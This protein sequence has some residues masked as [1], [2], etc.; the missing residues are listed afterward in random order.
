MRRAESSTTAASLLR[1]GWILVV[2]LATLLAWMATAEGYRPAEEGSGD[3]RRQLAVVSLGERTPTTWVVEIAD[4]LDEGRFEIVHG[5]QLRGRLR[6]RQVTQLEPGVDERIDQLAGA[7]KR[8]IAKFHGTGNETAIEAL[9]TPFEQA[10]RQPQAFARRPAFAERLFR[11]GMILVRAYRNLGETEGARGIARDLYRYLPGLEPSLAQ[12]RLEDIHFYY[13]ER[14]AVAATGA[15]LT[16]PV[17]GDASCRPYLN[18]TPISGGDAKVDSDHTHVVSTRCGDEWGPIWR[19]DLRPG[20]YATVPVSQRAPRRVELANWSRR[21]RRRVSQYLRVITHWTD[22]SATIGIGRPPSDDGAG[23]VA[24][25]VPADGE[26][27]WSTVDE[28][29]DVTPALRR[30]LPGVALQSPSERSAGGSD[31]KRWLDWTL[32]A[33]GSA[34]L[35]AGATFAALTEARAGRLPCASGGR[36][37][38]T[39]SLVA[40]PESCTQAQRRDLRL[41]RAGYVTTL[42]AGASLTTWGLLRNLQREPIEAAEQ[43]ARGPRISVQPVHRGAKAVLEFSW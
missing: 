15:K 41:Q 4:V 24:M 25:R 17:A 12:A 6:R 10:I 18:G 40:R 28:R 9:A 20:E 36:F 14:A 32:V 33:G 1:A 26:A 29:G 35:A 27:T 5:E 3:E 13:R 16:M 7:L 30:L 22:V 38:F 2:F 23:Y 31:A 19:V 37:P 21:G 34:G 8:G 42:L 11:A 43:T 39:R